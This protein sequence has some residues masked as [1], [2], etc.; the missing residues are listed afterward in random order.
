MYGRIKR[1]GR[2]PKT[3][4][5]ERPKFQVHLL[6]KPQYLQN[7]EA[8]GLNSPITSRT[9][10]P[11]GSETSRRST[12]KK[13]TKR[14]SNPPT[15]GGRGGN[16]K[17]KQTLETDY[18]YGSDFEDSTDHD[19][20][21]GLSESETEPEK[22]DPLDEMSDSDLSLSSFSTT[23]G[24]NKKFSYISR[25]S[26][27]PLWLQTERQIQPLELPRSSDDLLIPREY[28]MQTLS[29][30]EVLRH[31]K[32][33]IRLS[34]FRF[35]DFCAVLNFEEQSNLLV[36]IHVSLL[37]TIFRE[38]DTQQTHFGP[39]DQKDSAN[40]VLYFIDAMTWPEALR[41]YIESDKTFDEEVLNILNT[42]EYPFTDIEKR[43][44]VLQFLT[45]QILITSPVREDLIHE[46]KY[47]SYS[48]SQ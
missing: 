12:A 26:P 36:E 4:N 13:G 37:K 19:D 27:E 22:D 46:G 6:K 25:M 38:E 34:P 10:S 23:S 43:L 39:L 17:R 31:F 33:L 32:S 42:C 41:S 14:K 7:L 44:R 3:P 20:D 28:V 24:T 40:S 30:Y 35:E 15:R 18:H 1:R 21:L 11:Q 5:T 9:S 16:Q 48:C 29:I 2:P 45:D 47:F 8:R